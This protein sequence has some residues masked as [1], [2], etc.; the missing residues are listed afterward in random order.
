MFFLLLLFVSTEP[1][2]MERPAHSVEGCCKKMVSFL[3]SKSSATLESS[4]FFFYFCIFKQ[5][6]HILYLIFFVAD[7]S[8]KKAGSYPKK[9]VTQKGLRNV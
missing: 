3:D 5:H 7:K 9:E 6:S 4:I 1:P 2:E 8:P